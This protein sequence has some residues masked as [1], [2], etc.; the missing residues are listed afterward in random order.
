MERE[1]EGDGCVRRGVVGRL[2][3][4]TSPSV[5]QL[6]RAPWRRRLR[7][8]Y[9][10]TYCTTVHMHVHVYAVGCRLIARDASVA[11]AA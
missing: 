3:C 11:V 4:E 1:E 7:Y 9:S 2:S 8:R 6:Q 5:L 10:Y